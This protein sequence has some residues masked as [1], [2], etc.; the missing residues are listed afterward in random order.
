MTSGRQRTALAALSF[1]TTGLPIRNGSPFWWNDPPLPSRREA[2][3]VPPNRSRL[4]GCHSRG[5]AKKKG[6]ANLMEG[7]HP[8]EV[9]A[10]ARIA[11][12]A[13]LIIGLW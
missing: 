5:G 2:R 11:A 4:P 13:P 3:R 7:T 1:S 8:R 12:R 10:T 6:V 9:P